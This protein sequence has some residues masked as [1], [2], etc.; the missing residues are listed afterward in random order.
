MAEDKS[1]SAVFHPAQPLEGRILYPAM[2][3]VMAKEQDQLFFGYSQPTKTCCR[4]WPPDVGVRMSSKFI[5]P[6]TS[7]VDINTNV[8][9]H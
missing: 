6:G 8:C 1:G 7:S 4:Y 2:K 9:E 5:R 3:D